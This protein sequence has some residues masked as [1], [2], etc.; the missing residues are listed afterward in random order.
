MLTRRCAA[1]WCFFLTTRVGAQALADLPP[2]PATEA[3][4]GAWA[5]ASL[6]PAAALPHRGPL[7]N[8]PTSAAAL[9]NA[10]L[11]TVA[12]REFR[13]SVSEVTPR[14]AT[15]M[16]MAA[17]VKTRKFRV[18][19]RARLAEG[20]A[21]EKALNQQGVTTGQVGQ[22][23]YVGATYVFEATVSEA[24]AG[25][26]K[27]SFALGLAGAAV[28][29]GSSTDSLAIDVRVIDV[30]SGVVV[31]AVTV[32]KDIE[33][34]ETKVAGVG[35]ALT[36]WLT[37]GRAG[38]LAEALTPND[39]TT[40]ARRDSVDKSLREAIEEAIQTIAKQLGTP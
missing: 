4:A 14:G 20:A 1:I 13:S 26:R 34:V 17:L 16:F 21:A 25:D 36:H 31:D 27:S 2:P 5:D 3:A 18:L 32:R 12:I 39:Q 6:G 35:T 24:S 37:R 7:P 29:R 23:Q 8:A 11:P 10:A 38:A 28:G 22:S 15:D 30:E 33:S 9:R 19:E 40:S